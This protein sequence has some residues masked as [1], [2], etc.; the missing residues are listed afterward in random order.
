M[1]KVFYPDE[2]EKKQILRGTKIGEDMF[3]ADYLLKQM[4]LGYAPDNKTKFKYPKNLQNKGLKPINLLPGSI[5]NMRSRQWVV[6]RK[7]ET[8]KR[9]SGLYYLKGVELGTDSRELEISKNGTLID[10]K[11][12]NSNSP[13]YKFSEIFSN[14]YDEIGK[15][16]P[17]FDR[18]KE[19]A[20]ALAL[21]KYI[22]ENQY[23]IDYNLVKQIYESTI[24]PNYQI[25]VNSICHYENKNNEN[26]ITLNQDESAKQYLIENNIKINRQNLEMAKDYLNNSGGVYKCRQIQ[27]SNQLIMGGID[28]WSGILECEK[29]I[30]NESITSLSTNEDNFDVKIISV[31]NNKLSIDLTNCDVFEFPFLLKNKKCTICNID[32]N[33]SEIKIN[34]SLKNKYKSLNDHYCNEHNPFKCAICNQ[35]LI[36]TSFITV[37]ESYYHSHCLKCIYCSKN[38]DEKI[39]KCEEGFIHKECLENYNDDI[40]EKQARYFYERCPDCEFCE[41][42]ITENGFKIN[43]YNLHPECFEKI[44]KKGVDPGKSYIIEG[45]CNKC[46]ICKKVIIGECI[47]TID[48]NTHAECLYFIMF[49]INRCYQFLLKKNYSS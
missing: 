35:I 17:I 40:Y 34:E 31:K 27:M 8:I 16:Y 32:L 20:G 39:C 42:K 28:L 38:F 26:I 33:L 44:K 3:K 37:E 24:I 21:A 46:Y 6:T 15:V 36:N 12:Q 29:N 49:I 41:E 45:M 43:N 23:P 14:L 1:R 19:I 48:G 2:H 9:K 4:A 13:C 30:L 25:K 11:V 47:R 18:L 22:Y 5:G 7:I 10:K